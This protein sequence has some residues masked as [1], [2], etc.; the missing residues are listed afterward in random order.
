MTQGRARA[1]VH[2]GTDG[3]RSLDGIRSPTDRGKFVMGGDP[4]ETE[5]KTQGNAE[6]LEG[7]SRA[8]TMQ[9]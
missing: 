1:K 7:Q 8:A 2:G 9:D 5:T 4:G 3:D 6:N